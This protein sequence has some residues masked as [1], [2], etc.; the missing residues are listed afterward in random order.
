MMVAQFDTFEINLIHEGDAWKICDFMVANADRFKRYFPKT[1]EQNLNPT[2]SQLFVEKMVK[3]FENKDVF[4]FTL[5]HSETRELAG[6]IY[7]KN[8]NWDKKQGEF[9]YCIGYTFEDQGLTSKAINAL[10]KYAFNTLGLETLQIIVN[11]DNIP[12][13]NVATKN[14]FEWKKTLLNEFTPPGEQA[15]DMELYELYKN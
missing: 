15:L 13:L 7:I 14:N 6:L 10:S 5:K 2:L 1:L 4:L 12:S 8:L 11:K 3:Q 9:A